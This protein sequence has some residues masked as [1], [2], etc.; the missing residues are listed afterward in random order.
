M[1]FSR[2]VPAHLSVHRTRPL[3]Q[4]ELRGRFI[5]HKSVIDNTRDV[6]TNFALAGLVEG[7][8]E[9]MVF[10][11][12]RELGSTVVILQAIVPDAEHSWGRVMASREAVGAAARAARGQSLG[13]LCQ[14]HSHPGDDAR[15]SDGDDELVLLPFENMLSIVAPNFGTSFTALRKSC[16]HQFQDGRW[17]LCSPQSVEANIIV[18]SSLVDLRA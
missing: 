18:A 3:P 15:H 14:V 10:W 6:L 12:G 7:G 9:G 4:G 17:V 2:N 8:H 16:V 5:L 1:R 13:I 11:A